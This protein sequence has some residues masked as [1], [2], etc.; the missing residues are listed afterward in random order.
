[1]YIPLLR[2]TGLD[3]ELL[4]QWRQVWDLNP[5]PMETG[6]GLFEISV[7]CSRYG[8]VKYFFIRDLE[9]S[10]VIVVEDCLEAM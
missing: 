4:C 5:L 8:T 6:S 1:M 9:F 7:Y 3:F 10:E 2:E